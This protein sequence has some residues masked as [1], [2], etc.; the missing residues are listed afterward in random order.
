[1][2]Y[3]AFICSPFSA[4][5][6]VTLGTLKFKCAVRCRKKRGRAPQISDR[7]RPFMQM[8]RTC[9]TKILKG[10]FC[11]SVRQTC[12]HCVTRKYC[13]MRMPATENK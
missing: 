3:V 6:S 10:R 11:I 5:D 8:S 1:M 4:N 2:T 12:C 9:L 13:K 7:G